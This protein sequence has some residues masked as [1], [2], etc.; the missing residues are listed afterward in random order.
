MMVATTGRDLCGIPIPQEPGRRR[1]WIKYQLKIKG[2]SIAGLAQKHGVS[3]QVVSMTLT[4]SNPRWEFVIAQALDLTP[5]ELWPERYDPETSLPI[6][7]LAGEP[8]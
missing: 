5:S 6:S 3:R 1:E 4:N 8:A 2:L 7:Q